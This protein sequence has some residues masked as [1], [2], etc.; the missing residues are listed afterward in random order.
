MVCTWANTR[1][2]RLGWDSVNHGLTWLASAAVLAG[3]GHNGCAGLGVVP[4]PGEV[5]CVPLAAAVY[6]AQ[7]SL[8][9]RSRAAFALRMSRR[10]MLGKRQVSAP[11]IAQ[12]ATH[13]ALRLAHRRFQPGEGVGV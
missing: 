3:S 10:E 5:T 12:R 4:E 2:L 6:V 11:L 1:V 8:G 13:G 9:P 7:R